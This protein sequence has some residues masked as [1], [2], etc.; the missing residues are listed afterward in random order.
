MAEILFLFDVHLCVC[1]SV[2]C[3][4]LTRQSAQFKTVKATDFKSDMHVPRNNMDMTLQNF[5]KRGVYKNSLGRDTHSHK[6]LKVYTSKIDT[7]S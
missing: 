5:L 1:V 3:A 4:Q 6:R 7:C 2:Q